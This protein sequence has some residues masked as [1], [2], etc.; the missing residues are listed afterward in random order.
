MERMGVV[1]TLP[2]LRFTPSANAVCSFD[3][4]TDDDEVLH[5]VTW[6]SVAE[7]V[8][9][10]V[11][12]DYKVLLNGTSKL[13]WWTDTEGQKHSKEEFTAQRLRVLQKPS[14]PKYCCLSCTHWQFDCMTGC[15]N[16]FGSRID[17]ETCDVQ[18]DICISVTLEGELMNRD[19][20]EKK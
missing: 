20:W 6:N 12:L 19:C 5:V 1:V 11:K 15:Y 4:E 18:D 10:F 9:K 17:R 13:R 3:V 16:A 2:E 7:N 14:Y 8:N